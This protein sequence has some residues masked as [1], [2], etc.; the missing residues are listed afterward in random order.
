MLFYMLLH[1]QHWAMLD[2]AMV[3]SAYIGTLS[4]CFL[5]FLFPI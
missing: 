3:L 5:F 4:V 2:F 1:E